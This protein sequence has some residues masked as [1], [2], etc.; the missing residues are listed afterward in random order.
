MKKVRWHLDTGFAGYMHEGEF[1]IED[2]TA[3]DEIEEMAKEEA[4]NFIDWSY[5]IVE[6]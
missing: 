1:E 6:E 2:D 4:F 3:E 5:E